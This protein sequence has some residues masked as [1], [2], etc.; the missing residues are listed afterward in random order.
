MEFS[1]CWDA[2][3]YCEAS[4]MASSVSL[5][6]SQR[7]VQRRGGLN[8]TPSPIRLNQLPRQTHGCK[9]PSGMSHHTSVNLLETILRPTWSFSLKAI[10][11][12]PLCTSASLMLSPV[13]VTSG[14][15]SGAFW[16]RSLDFCISRVGQLRQ[17]IRG[18]GTLVTRSSVRQTYS[19]LAV[20][21][22][23]EGLGEIS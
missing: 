1:Q 5:L 16:G 18:G 19:E 23:R 7:I 12:R 3:A 20:V 21:D 13:H 4:L 11:L 14:V 10:H 2:V 17:F 15:P 8:S 9:P 22:T 6:S